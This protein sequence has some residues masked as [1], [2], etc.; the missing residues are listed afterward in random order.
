MT[1]RAKR[2][3]IM[4][5]FLGSQSGYNAEKYSNWLIHLHVDKLILSRIKQ[6]LIQLQVP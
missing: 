4:H 6:V 2:K 1:E 5:P 3:T